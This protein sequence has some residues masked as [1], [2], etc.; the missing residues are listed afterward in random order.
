MEESLCIVVPCYNE[1]ESLSFFFEAMEALEG[2]LP[3]KVSYVLVNDGSKDDT[4]SVMRKAN[5]RRP[6]DVHYISF[7]RNFGKEAA[8]AAGMRR[9]VDDDYDLV[10]VMDADLQDPPSLLP[11]MIDQVVVHGHDV[12]AA[13]RTTRAGESPIRS[14][15]AHR[16]YIMMNKIS[17]VE[18]KDGA[19]DFRVMTNRVAKAVVDLRERNRFSKGLFSWAGFETV[20]IPYENIERAHGQ[21]GWSFLSLV[22]YAIEGIVAFSTVPLEIISVAGLIAFLFALVFLLFVIIRALMFGDPVAGWPSLMAVITLFGGINLLGVGTV[23][24]YIS[25]IYSE[26]KNR[27]LYIIE[28][29]K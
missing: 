9:A 10:S 12:A 2:Q 11:Q 26:T 15:F 28:E 3:V 20:W 13:Y 4:L 7:S 6:D 14:W 17:D 25:K 29:E 8:L 5:A 18:M 27:P 22:R 24:L 1:G 16:F 21:T 19:R 23:G